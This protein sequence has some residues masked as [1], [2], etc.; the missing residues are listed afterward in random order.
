[1]L[2]DH[3]TWRSFFSLR[4]RPLIK[5]DRKTVITAPRGYTRILAC[6]HCQQR[7]VKCDRNTPCAACIKAGIAASCVPNSPAPVRMRR[8]PVQ[9]LGRRLARCEELLLQHANVE[10]STPSPIP[11]QIADND[12][13]NSSGGSPM[14][15]ASLKRACLVIQNESS[16]RV[17]DSHLWAALYEEV[18]FRPSLRVHVVSYLHTNDLFN[19]CETCDASWKPKTPKSP[20]I[21]M[22]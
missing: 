15:V 13:V 6:A 10:Q 14:N 19:S 17:M 21:K 22:A 2:R 12:S 9:D 1:M 16:T 4:Y 11:E 18:S 3:L 8:R 5:M 7:K 20:M